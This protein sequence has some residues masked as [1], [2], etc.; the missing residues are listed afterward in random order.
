VVGGE[1]E[2]DDTATEFDTEAGTE[3]FGKNEAGSNELVGAV[4]ATSSTVTATLVLTDGASS[5]QPA[6][7][8]TAPTASIPVVETDAP[9]S[10]TVIASATAET[11]AE[12]TPALET[13]GPTT[14]TLTISAT[15]EAAAAITLTVTPTQESST[16]PGEAEPTAT[17]SR[18]A[19]VDP[20][21]EHM[22]GERVEVQP[23]TPADASPSEPPEPPTPDPVSLPPEPD[24]PPGAGD[25]PAPD[26]LPT[27][28]W[29]IEAP[30]VPF[31]MAGGVMI[32]L[33][34]VGAAALLKRHE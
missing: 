24:L 26:S 11:A 22:A 7:E 18:P 27:T 34:V 28:G 31:W 32:L 29:R 6:I 19:V 16:F 12:T 15:A 9:I 1:T 25:V 21:M 3:I 33:L 2:A 4:P 14:P 17:P 8:G 23:D 5:G 30:S 20:I 10:T 13:G